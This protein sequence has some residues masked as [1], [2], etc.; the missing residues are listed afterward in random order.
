MI[1]FGDDGEKFGVWPDTKRHVY[2]ERWL[3][4]FFEALSANQSWLRVT[5]PSEVLEN[6]PPLG[7]LY[8][9]EGSYREM[10]EWALPP[11]RIEAFED[12]H[13]ELESEGKWER[14]SAFVRQPKRMR[15]SVRRAA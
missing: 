13:R 10:T 5:T 3:A 8:I 4:R 7:K 9:P 11:A 14:V 15:S 6:V 1:V 12:L 2:D